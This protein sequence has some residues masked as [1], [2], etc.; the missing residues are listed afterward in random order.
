MKQVRLMFIMAMQKTQ[1]LIFLSTTPEKMLIPFFYPTI[2]AM[3]SSL[4]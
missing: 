3:L 1:N 2:K 4:F